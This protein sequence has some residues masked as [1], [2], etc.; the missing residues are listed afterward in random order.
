[1]KATRTLDEDA[2][3]RTGHGRRSA[4]R[5]ADVVTERFWLTVVATVIACAALPKQPM[6][7]VRDPAFF[8]YVGR[9]LIHG[10]TL[11][12]VVWTTSCRASTS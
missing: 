12:A 6:F 10:Q 5:F 3:V 11:Y 2:G 8:A 4:E 7:P 9:T 1:M